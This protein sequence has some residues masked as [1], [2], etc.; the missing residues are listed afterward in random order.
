MWG[1]V[2][3]WLNTDLAS[4]LHIMS[5]VLLQQKRDSKGGQDGCASCYRC[6]NAVT[7]ETWWGRQSNGVVKKAESLDLAH[8]TEVVKR[9]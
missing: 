9:G 8:P 6:C 2:L 3:V 7:Q 1:W 4:S 5:P